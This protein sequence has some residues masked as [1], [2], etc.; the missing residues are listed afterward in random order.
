M[1]VSEMIERL[2]YLVARR[3]IPLN[4]HPVFS[5]REDRE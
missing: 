4:A 5:A 3:L 2:A 1:A